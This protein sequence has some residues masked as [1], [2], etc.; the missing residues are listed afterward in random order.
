MVLTSIKGYERFVAFLYLDLV[1]KREKR[2]KMM[3]TMM[4][5]KLKTMMRRTERLL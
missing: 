1:S 4:L 3:T 2:P 5:R